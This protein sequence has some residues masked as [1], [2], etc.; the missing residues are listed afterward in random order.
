MS[1]TLLVICGFNDE[2]RLALTG[3]AEA[4]P[5]FPNKVEHRKPNFPTKLAAT[6]GCEN[7]SNEM[8]KLL[9]TSG[10]FFGTYLD[11]HVP[12]SSKG[13]KVPESSK[14]FFEL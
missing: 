3:P 9:P 11:F 8:C 10:R 2:Y 1:F 5:I 12:E 6:V 14:F 13:G 4:L 7:P